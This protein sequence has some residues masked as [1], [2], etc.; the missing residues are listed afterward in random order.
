ARGPTR[1]RRYTNFQFVS[2]ISAATLVA[3]GGMVLS[4]WMFDIASFK[5]VS[6]GWAT[7]KV[8]TAACFIL[9]GISLWCLRTERPAA[10]HVRLAGQICAGLVAIVALL[11]VGEALLGADFGIDQALMRQPPAPT[12]TASPGRMSAATAFCF[13]LL[14]LAL[15]ALDGKTRRGF[16]PAP[17]LALL[18]TTIGILT[19]VGYLYEV[20]SLYA[21]SPF[22]SMAAH[23]AL[24]FVVASLGI[25][26][27]R[28]G[29]GPFGIL[30]ADGIG[31]TMARRLLPLA[32]VLPILI[33]GLRMQ[34]ERAGLYGFEFGLALFATANVVVFAVLI[35]LTAV[36]LNRVDS[37][38]R[39]SERALRASEHRFRALLEHG[40]DSISLIDKDNRILYLSPS[41]AAVEGYAAEEMIGRSG[42][43]HTH[44]DDLPL[45]QGYIGQL[46]ENPGLPVPVLW[47]RRHK[48]GH[49]I[50]LEGV[51]TNLLDDPA[52]GAIVT[53]YRDVTERRRAEQSIEA[54]NQSLARHNAELDA[55]RARWK[56]VVEGIA[57]EV[58]VCDTQGR[59]SLVNLPAVTQM[60]LKEFKDKSVEQIAAVVD[61]LKPDG[62][63]RAHADAPLLRALDGETVRVEEI[64]RDRETGRTRW[65]HV[66]AAP[67]RDA[68][69]TIMGA[70]AVIRDITDYKRAGEE[71]RRLNSELERRVEQRTAE[72]GNKNRELETFSYSVSHDLKAPLRG[73][74][75]YSRLLLTEYEDKLDEDGR[76]FLRN[77]RTATLQMQQLIDDLLAYSRLE[78]RTVSAS[79]VEPLLVVESI[80]AERRQDLEAVR[81]T[82]D[83]AAHAVRADPEGISMALRNLIDNALKFS[84]LRQPPVIEI[85]SRIEGDRHIISVRDNGAGFDMQYHDRIFQIFQRLHRAEDY[86][87]TGVGLAIVHKAMERMGGRAWAQSEPDKG[88]TFYIDLPCDDVPGSAAGGADPMRRS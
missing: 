30:S 34:G 75:G 84:R 81:L 40:A 76:A 35:W 29:E 27:A 1:S 72:L 68:G 10:S 63:L 22:S 28:P 14:G 44:P 24:L 53:N 8:N 33:G 19:L 11:T 55:E 43:E 23:T 51:A 36:W 45:L 78:R 86:A 12:D 65:R 67:I 60:N 48:N 85:R 52:V 42:I 15:L 64:M 61:I 2:V 38:R 80:L 54:L 39:E 13:L 3:G 37:K 66:S 7:M 4:G 6:P 70:V 88:A 31:S 46:L 79:R 5:S 32:I 49:W 47:R 62:Q 17:A 77:I 20:R 57:D 69:G 71:I 18:T 73:I 25:L 41:V 16:R 56:G 26:Y 83:V 50:W 58:W 21:I 59:M 87:G 82:V 74:D 9:A